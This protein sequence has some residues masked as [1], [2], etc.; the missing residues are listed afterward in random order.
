MWP[1]FI[2]YSLP[3][4][5]FDKDPLKFPPTA[6]DGTLHII[7][8]IQDLYRDY[9]ALHIRR[10]TTQ[11]LYQT[12]TPTPE[13]IE[14]EPAVQFINALAY[15]KEMEIIKYRFSKPVPPKPRDYVLDIVI[16]DIAP[17]I[18]RR[19]SVCSGMS[20]SL[21]QDK[22]ICPLMGWLRNYHAYIF[23]D[24]R[25]GAQFGPDD[26]KA[27]DMTHLPLNGFVVLNDKKFTIA[28]V[29]RNKND[30][31]YYSYDLG[32]HFEHIIRLTGIRSQEDSTGR[33]VVMNGSMAPLPEDSQGLH[34]QKGNSGYQNLLN[35]WKSAPPKKRESIAKEV[36]LAVNYA[37]RQETFDP[38]RFD[39]AECQAELNK[40]F[41]S[42]TSLRTG[43]KQI[44]FPTPTSLPAPNS[45]I[46]NR[47]GK[48]KEV[49]QSIHEGRRFIK[50]TCSAVRDHKYNAT[51]VCGNVF[52]LLLCGNCKMRWYCSVVHQI[53]DRSVNSKTTNNTKDRASNLP[54][55]EK[56]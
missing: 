20:L 15:K 7:W 39:V 11:F 50:E 24:A 31:M 14:F 54:V 49:I 56:N 1:L 41:A 43:C 23:T 9:F 33:C 47:N 4:F 52:Q 19:V 8:G 35:V 55:D 12:K 48:T 3:V 37:S 51:C 36:S 30:I 6:G 18:W 40:A 16:S 13:P 25:D 21:F 10:M 38:Y 27:P 32:D 44:A 42:N 2:L 22:V 34:D 5:E 53:D 29:L 26:M 46:V 45:F 28:D 17:R